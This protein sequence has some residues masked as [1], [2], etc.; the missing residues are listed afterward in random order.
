MHKH[1]LRGLVCSVHWRRIRHLLIQKSVIHRKIVWMMMMMRMMRKK[2]PMN[3]KP[4][5][6]FSHKFKKYVLRIPQKLEEISNFFRIMF[7]L[8]ATSVKVKL[9]THQML[10]FKR[11]PSTTISMFSC[12]EDESNPKS[13]P[14]KYSLFLQDD[15]DG[16]SMY[17]RKTT[18]VWLF[19]E[20]ECVSSDR[21]FR[22]RWHANS[23]ILTL[24][25][26]S[27]RL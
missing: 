21:L 20:G 17:I 3:P 1:Q 5:P 7:L 26:L 14:R 16:K 24:H 15:L 22:V 2:T 10:L 19:Q 4:M 9:Q 8:I 25:P 12:L 6:F 13:K 11:S 18:A 27:S 23:H